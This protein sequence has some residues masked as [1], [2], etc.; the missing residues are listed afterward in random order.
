MQTQKPELAFLIVPKEVPP[1]GSARVNKQIGAFCLEAQ[2]FGS[3]TASS[4]PP[5]RTPGQGAGGMEGG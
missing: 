3:S 4:S 2:S 5:L 1:E